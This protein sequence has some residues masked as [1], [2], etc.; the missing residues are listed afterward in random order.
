MQMARRSCGQGCK[1]VASGL[2]CPTGL[3]YTWHLKP[4][5]WRI[6]WKAGSSG[7]IGPATLQ[8]SFRWADHIYHQALPTSLLHLV[9]FPAWPQG[10]S[11]LG[12][13][14]DGIKFTDQGPLGRTNVCVGSA[15]YRHR[16]QLFVLLLREKWRSSASVFVPSNLNTHR[17]WLG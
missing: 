13:L 6:S 7:N 14:D 1:L 15:F 8:S 17:P 10:H 5:I 16:K 11:G 9:T 4:G 2:L 12:S 3:T